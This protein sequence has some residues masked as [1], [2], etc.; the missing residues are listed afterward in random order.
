MGIDGFG[1]KTFLNRS[2]LYM[3]MYS[4]LFYAH[5]DATEKPS[6][7]DLWYV[8]NAQEML[9]KSGNGKIILCKNT[10]E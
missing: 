2:V 9:E 7:L 10:I 3:K 1:T 4:A 6:L 5:A 8:G